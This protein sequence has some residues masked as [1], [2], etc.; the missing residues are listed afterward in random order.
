ME[1]GPRKEV[2]RIPTS[3]TLQ[4][5]SKVKETERYD[6]NNDKDFQTKN[7]EGTTSKTTHEPSWD[8]LTTA[9]EKYLRRR[10]TK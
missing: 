10:L 2:Q 3:L 8:V 7:W 4:T 1:N 9:Y 5:K 6:L